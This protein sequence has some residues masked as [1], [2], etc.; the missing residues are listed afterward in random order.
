MIPMPDPA[1]ETTTSA[2]GTTIGYL[3]LGAGPALVI[4]HGS[5]ATSEQWIPAGHLAE[6]FTCYVHD[7][8]GRGRSGD[9]TTYSMATEVADIAAMMSVAGAGAHLLGHSYGALCTL[10]YAETHPLDGTLLLFEPPLAVDGPV[11]GPGLSAYR[12]LVEAE[13]LDSAFAFAL[14]NFVRV[15]AEAV[16]EIRRTPLWDACVPLAS[17]WVRELEQID[18]LGDDLRHYAAIDAPVHLIAGTLTTPFLYKSAHTLVD[19]VPQ[20]TITDL[21]GRDHFAHLVD[22][23]QFA[24]T[25]RTAIG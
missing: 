17:T 6:H 22:P 14:V 16:P 19:V 7:R 1:L 9:T 25:V 12:D 11:A 21:P 3:R 15:P 13:D 2:D 18:A 4:T 10:A 8:R 24:A 5:V 20:A 23:A